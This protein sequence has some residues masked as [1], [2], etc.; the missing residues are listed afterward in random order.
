MAKGVK[1]GHADP[2]RWTSEEESKYVVNA[3]IRYTRTAILMV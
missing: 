2:A 1:P 3:L